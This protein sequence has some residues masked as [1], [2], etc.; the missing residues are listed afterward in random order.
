MTIKDKLLE[1]REYLNERAD[2]EYDN[3][4]GVITCNKE[5]DMLVLIDEILEEIK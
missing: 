3:E 4:R 1:V 2:A 5:M